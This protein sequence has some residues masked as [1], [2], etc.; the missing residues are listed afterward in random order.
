MQVI[1]EELA[2]AKSQLLASQLSKKSFENND[3]LTKFHTGLPK[4]E[5]LN[6]IFNLVHP[7]IKTTSQ[8]PLNPCYVQAT[9]PAVFQRNFGK[10][11]S[12]IDCFEV[13]IDKQQV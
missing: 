5:V 13:F 8:N 2:L 9:M 7:H 1:T 11:V 10:R 3:E 6:H 4:F 12:V